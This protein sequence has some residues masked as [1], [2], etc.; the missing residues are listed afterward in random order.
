MLT[1]VTEANAMALDMLNH[2]VAAIFRNE[3]RDVVFVFVP[4]IKR[5][6][7]YEKGEVV[8]VRE[9]LGDCS[10]S[11]GII[12][13]VPK[14]GWQAVAVHELVHFYNPKM[15]EA[16]VRKRTME[17]ITYLKS[18]MLWGEQ[19]PGIVDNETH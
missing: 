9:T 14:E 4:M 15:R 2:R 3:V 17:V 7:Q 6:Q 8:T 16:T 11:Q 1:T 19:K 12:R 10:I 13:L 5:L 18:P